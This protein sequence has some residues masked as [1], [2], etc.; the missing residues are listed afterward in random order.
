MVTFPLIADK[1][2]D[3]REEDHPE[4]IL[5]EYRSGGYIHKK[6]QYFRNFKYG[7]EGDVNWLFADG[8]VKINIE[9][10]QRHNICKQD[11]WITWYEQRFDYY[12]QADTESA[13][14]GIFD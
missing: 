11:W 8:S 5:R 10:K 13:Y 2:K 12:I 6:E 9:V 7:Y 3:F 4:Y 14:D 1:Q